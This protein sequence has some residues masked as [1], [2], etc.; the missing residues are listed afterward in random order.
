MTG[1]MYKRN[2]PDKTSKS[3]RYR[4]HT[5]TKLEGYDDGKTPMAC[6]NRRQK[7]LERG[8]SIFKAFFVNMD[9]SVPSV[10]NAELVCFE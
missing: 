1:R 9:S 4:Q 7:H 10:L 8:Y 6:D 5:Y 3:S 2:K